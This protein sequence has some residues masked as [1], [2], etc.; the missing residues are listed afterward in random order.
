M[1]AA[2]FIVR[3][4]HKK[5]SGQILKVSKRSFNFRCSHNDQNLRNHSSV[6][7]SDFSHF[8]SQI[9]DLEVKIRGVKV[10]NHWNLHI[11]RKNNVCC[12]KM[13]L[14]AMLAND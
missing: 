13:W 2:C 12:M 5:E 10:I 1:L 8:F 4:I 6:T 11:Y 14:N 3:A 7:N 9:L